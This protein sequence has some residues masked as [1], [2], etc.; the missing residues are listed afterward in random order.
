VVQREHRAGGCGFGQLGAQP[1]QLLGPQLT[2]PLARNG[3]VQH[4]DAQP[5]EPGD[6]VERA[7]IGGLP[8]QFGAQCGAVVVVPGDQHDRHRH[9]GQR[10]PQSLVLRGPAVLG[11]VARQQQPG[12][13]P[14]RRHRCE[15]PLEHRQSVAGR[16]WVVFFADVQVGQ[17]D[18][19]VRRFHGSD[20][21]NAMI[22]TGSTRSNLR[23][24]GEQRRDEGV[25][26]R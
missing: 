9:P 16:P 15:R 25:P 18:Q 23:R 17:L 19:G 12:D 21:A 4:D 13:R 3:A 6:V 11:Q 5:V 10:G 2:V 8:G 24:S 7:G 1:L 14:G 20:P 26:G 22:G